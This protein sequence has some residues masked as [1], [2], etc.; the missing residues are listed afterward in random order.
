MI[1]KRIKGALN[2]IKIDEDVRVDLS[3]GICEYSDFEKDL[4]IE[5][6]IKAADNE[7]YQMKKEQR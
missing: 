4:D 2:N 5:D 3:Y 6:L 1:I 7:M